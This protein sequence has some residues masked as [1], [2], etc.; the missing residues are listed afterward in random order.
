[1]G[2]KKKNKGHLTI[3]NRLENYYLNENHTE[4]NEI[5]WHAW[6]QN[7]RWISQLL[8]TTMSSFPTYS[9]HDESHAVTVL[10]NI[11]MILG[12]KRIQELSASD[13]FM[14][15]HAVYI[16][17]IGMVITHTDREDIVKNEKFIDMVNE[18]SEEGDEVFQKAIKALQQTQYEYDDVDTR[19]EQLKKLYID[20]L[21]VYYA[22]LHLIAN[23]QRS[24]HGELSTERL[25]EWTLKSEKLGAGFSMAGIPQRIFLL[26]AKCAGLHTD[27]DFEHIMSLPQEDNGYVSDYLHPRFIAVL[28][29]LGDILDMD[30]DRF[31]PLTR[32]LIGVLPELSE[33]HYEKHQAIR[34]LYIRPDIISIEADCNTQEALRMV[35]KECNILKNILKDAG[36]N[37][38]LIC[39]RN[40]SGA[41]PTIDSVKLYLKGIQIPEELITT[42][43]RISQR[44]AFSILEGSN[45][46]KGQY[47]F[48]RE[49]LQNAIDASKMQ[50]WQECVR[51]RGYYSPKEQLQKMSPGELGDILSTD[52]FPIEIEMQI[53]KR[54]EKREDFSIT[55]E[56]IRELRQNSKNKWQYG[57]KVRIKD[58]GTGID[59]ESILNIAKVG[60]SRKRERHIIKEMP[61]WLKPTAEF[62]IGIQSAFILTDMFKCYTSTRSNEK[63]EITFST[64]KSNYYEGYINV[65]PRLNFNT[66][67]DAYGTG[68]EVF[69][70]A[71]RKLTHEMYPSAWD[72]KDYFDDDYEELR[73]LRH[74]AELL[75]QMALYLDEQI[76]EQL[77]PIHLKIDTIPE[78]EIPINTSDK[79]RLKKIKCNL[80]QK[81]TW[82]EKLKAFASQQKDNN[83]EEQIQSLQPN[84]IWNES[85]KSWIFYY[86]KN[87]NSVKTGELGDSKNIL[88]EKNERSI[89]LLDCWDG[90][91][92]FWD[93]VLCTFCTVNMKNYLLRE[94]QEIEKLDVHCEKRNIYSGVLIYYKGIELDAIELPD[95]GNEL[96]ET[97]DIKGKLA[98]EYINLSRRGFTDSG[99]L[100]FLREI[101]EPLLESLH[102]ILRGMNKNQSE[103]LKCGILSGLEQKKKLYETLNK[104]LEGYDQSAG[105]IEAICS[106]SQIT[107]F[108]KKEEK[109]RIRELQEKI[110]L[111]CKE[112]VIIITMLAFFAQKSVFN[113]LISPEC[114]LE[115]GEI[116]CW[117]E[118]LEE[119]RKYGQWLSTEL[120]DKSVLFK[121][122]LRPEVD[123]VNMVAGT[124]TASKIINFVDIFSNNNQFMIV[125]KRENVSAPWK[126]YLT[127]IFTKKGKENCESPIDL[128]KHYIL[129][130]NYLDEKNEIKNKL[131]EV[132]QAALKAA[133]YY[134][135]YANGLSGEMSPGEHLQQY[136]LKW[137]LKYIPTVALF[138][139]DDGN[140]R[141]NIIHGKVFP[142]VYVNQEYQVLVLKRI[143]ENVRKYGIQRFS[144][145]AWQKMEYLKCEKLPYSH[146]F[147]KR[148]YISKESYGKVIFPLGEVELR[149]I[150]KRMDSPDARENAE[151]LDR[152]FGLLNIKKYL[153]EKLYDTSGSLDKQ[154]KAICNQKKEGEFCYKEIYEKFKKDWAN[155]LRNI[156]VIIDEMRDEY[157]SFTLSCLNQKQVPK[158]AT[159]KKFSLGELQ[160]FEEQCDYINTCILLKV[161]GG[162]YGMDCSEPIKKLSEEYRSSFAAGWSYVIHREYMQDASEV[163]KYKREY[164]KLLDSE[165]TEEFK[166]QQRILSYIE[167]HG[168]FG[169]R[170]NSLWS[171]WIRCIRELFDVYIFIEMNALGSPQKRLPDMESIVRRLG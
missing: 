84:R 55:K 10:H 135:R 147:V 39:P 61:E 133:E 100:F 41:L 24:E 68:F 159:K 80:D 97:I 26:I 81:Q 31:H 110:L 111:L 23:Y 33:R 155:G 154:I 114:D 89:G 14:L 5:L 45:V 115:T 162:Y 34:R 85:G 50:Y 16:H 70:P 102:N 161:L 96:F 73:P 43:F 38:M 19:E 107:I 145:P 113:P 128:L 54:N 122:E 94:Q 167:K 116:C 136:F 53:V 170:S 12:E 59:K 3:E 42:Q 137:L 88:I 163:A 120:K 9:K 108:I 126:Q 71:K 77:F 18:L 132:S 151:K 127:P 119:V 134:G 58:F 166:K 112:N 124:G 103:K 15:L 156:S 4:R 140:T 29:Q 72:G 48:L 91:F 157:R 92:Y 13:C 69:V 52:I 149:E 76:G 28:L 171:C 27:S 158:Q 32:E 65:Q 20:K 153:S 104:I 62:G 1:M 37:W 40:F 51:T 67:D 109:Q 44:K 86:N 66:R 8:E 165:N 160:N 78:I 82:Y 83:L 64:V 101:Y 168:G 90:H 56:D 22:I 60:N 121:I 148:G 130:N 7:K 98:R 95:I 79:N 47:V 75:A 46:Y 139:S 150:A 142:F 129:T 141:V 17:D 93:N 131:L 11:E 57:V 36:Y 49:F 87:K 106:D 63:Y 123:L 6:C 169:L 152:L 125:S 2:R 144:I 143:L 30:N 21:S 117:N 35:R 164:L 146:Y 118:I 25:S 105:F 74:S 138:M 99:R